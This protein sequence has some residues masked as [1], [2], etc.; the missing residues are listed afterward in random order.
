MHSRQQ[1]W[2]LLGWLKSGWVLKRQHFGL[3]FSLKIKRKTR[4]FHTSQQQ[5]NTGGF[6]S[7][8]SRANSRA[9]VLSMLSDWPGLLS[10]LTGCSHLCHR[11][12]TPALFLPL[13]S[14]NVCCEEGLYTADRA[15]ALCHHHAHSLAVN[16]PDE[17]LLFPY[18][19]RIW[20]L[21]YFFNRKLTRENLLNVQSKWFELL[22]EMRVQE[23]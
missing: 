21:M 13:T 9:L 8:L 12:F 17:D 14:Q 15:S 10:H 7:F 4:H 2:K 22:Q 19:G 18:M 5:K 23:I 3:N 16:A 11:L 20:H 1:G 6:S